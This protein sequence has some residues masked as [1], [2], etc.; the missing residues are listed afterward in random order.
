VPEA[1]NLY[2]RQ[3][4]VMYVSGDPVVDAAG[5]KYEG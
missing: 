4:P 5:S 2:T 1:T 3:K